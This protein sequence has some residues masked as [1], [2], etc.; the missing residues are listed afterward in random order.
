MPMPNPDLQNKKMDEIQN[1]MKT[2]IQNGDG[3]GFIKA[4]TQLAEEIQNNILAEAKS[5]ETQ[6]RNA[7]SDQ[8]VAI[9]RGLNPL[10]QEEKEY[11][12]EVITSG[13]FVG[14]QKLLPPTVFDR[15][16]EDLKANHELLKLIKFQNTSGVTEW[17]IREDDVQA[18]WWGKL[19]DS[20]KKKLENTFGKI[21]VDMYK[22]SAYMPVAKSMLDLGPE[23]LDRF[24]REVLFESLAIALE[25]AIIA[26]TG[27]DQPIG[28]MKKLVGTNDQGE[29]E[30][31]TPVPLADLK[32]V[33]L[34]SKVM[35][36]LT[37]NGTRTVNKVL[38][39]VNPLDYWEKIFAATTL[40]TV[41]GTYVY[42]VLPI[43]ADIV[44]SV[45]VPK[46]KMVV[47]IAKNYF[48]GVGS[49]QKIEAD[50]SYKFLEDERTYLAK[51]YATGRPDTDESFIVFDITNLATE[52]PTV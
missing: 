31:K 21:R 32:P 14:T 49:T 46:G 43:P 24:V 34:G 51:M 29:K 36:P 19:E 45:A 25:L 13:S 22:L 5:L 9:Q 26:G 44:Q 37:K 40:L 10:N 6:A 38:M 42:G 8:Q 50:D 17:I 7:Y 1:N 11:Y 35:A 3:E 30:D 20:I 41:G 28:M 15:V 27:K 23:W 52:I 33:T 48:L 12:N 16:F 18:A 47:G 39:V 4:Q 2:A